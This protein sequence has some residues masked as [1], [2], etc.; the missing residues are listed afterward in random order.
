MFKHAD[1]PANIC[2]EDSETPWLTSRT[3]D[4]IDQAKDP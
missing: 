3:I 4:F 1:K 2:E